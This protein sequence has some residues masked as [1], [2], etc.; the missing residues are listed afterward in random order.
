ME[1][2]SDQSGYVTGI[3]FYKFAGNTGTHTGQLWSINGANRN[4]IAS[5]TFSGETASG[6]QTASFSIPVWIMANTAYT[7]S[8]TARNG[9]YAAD[10]NYFSSPVVS[11]PLHAIAAG[12]NYNADTFPTNTNI[13]N[14]WVDVN[15]QPV[16][17]PMSL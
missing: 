7:V 12:Y 2:T 5:V 8:Y 1:F 14:Y 17:Y 13:T 6:W 11:S 10:A 3:R 16:E 4:A 9:H 15:F